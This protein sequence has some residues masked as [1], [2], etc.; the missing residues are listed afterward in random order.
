MIMCKNGKKVFEIYI[1]EP[2][3]D[4][5]CPVCRGRRGGTKHRE[6]HPPIILN[7]GGVALT[8]RE[9]H[10]EIP[11][12]VGHVDLVGAVRK[13]AE[14][15]YDNGWDWVVEAQTDDEIKKELGNLLFVCEAI[16]HYQEIVD[17]LVMMK[18]DRNVWKGCD[19][20]WG[21]ATT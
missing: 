8:R 11:L 9:K 12:Q 19:I 6:N 10:Y 1:V 7:D 14:K 16:A 18:N 2:G 21:W 4:T 17:L 3:G 5:L 20:V 13:H 15:H